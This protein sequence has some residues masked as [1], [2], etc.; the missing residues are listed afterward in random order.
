V[1]GEKEVPRIGW[2]IEELEQLRTFVD[3]CIAGLLHASHAVEFAHQQREVD[4]VLRKPDRFGAEHAF[5]KVL[6]EAKR[7]G[8]FA[9][10]EMPAGF[11]Y[12][13]SLA[14]I[15]MKEEVR[16][17]FQPGVGRF[18]AIL[19]AVE[20]GGPVHDGV[21]RAFLELSEVRHVL[22]HRRS[23]ADAKLLERCPWLPVK[24][25]DLLQVSET[26]LHFYHL[27][28]LWYV[29]EIERRLA[30]WQDRTQPVQEADLQATLEKRIVEAHANLQAAHR[31]E[32]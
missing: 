10:R 26:D 9:E 28:C 8:E 7:L 11:P 4:R 23:K 27:A 20:L 3:V 2:V 29:V 12:L 24:P 14:T 1:S 6:K 13:F 25:G 30:M 22:V 15:R 5:Q 16:A 31:T 18:E 32:L 21:R 19:N 17:N